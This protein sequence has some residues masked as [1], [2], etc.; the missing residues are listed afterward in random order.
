MKVAT[1]IRKTIGIVKNM[2]G[3]ILIPRGVSIG[4]QNAL[5]YSQPTIRRALRGADDTDAARRIRRYALQNG[6]VELVRPSC[7]KVAGRL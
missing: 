5:G 7:V 6:G 1:N 2:A 4:I 3:V